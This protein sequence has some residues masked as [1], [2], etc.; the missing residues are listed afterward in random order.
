MRINP[1]AIGIQ[2]LSLLSLLLVWTLTAA[3][4]PTE[5]LPPPWQVFERIYDEIS[6]GELVYHCM[7]TLG[8]VIAAFTLAMVI[9]IM[10]GLVMGLQKAIGRFFDPWLL[11]MLNLPALVI[12][13]LSYLWVGLNEVAAILAVTINKIPNVAVTLREGAKALDRDLL[14]MARCYR[15]SKRTTLTEVIWPQLTPFIAAAARSGLALVWKIVLVVE[16]LGRSNGVGFQLHLYFQM[17]DITGILAYSIAFIV[18]IWVIEY[19]AVR[20]WEQHVNSWR[21]A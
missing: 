13:I 8:R 5:L 20:P 12:I 14:E 6:K 11:L 10:I 1:E 3:F 7:A 18:I 2:L 4:A 19:A 17:F 9:G 21:K 16:L 15:L